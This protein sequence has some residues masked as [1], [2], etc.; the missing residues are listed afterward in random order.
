MRRFRHGPGSDGE[1]TE[2]L[3]E[4][5]KHLRGLAGRHL[6]PG[7]TLAI[8]VRD[9]DLAGRIEPRAACRAKSAS[10]AA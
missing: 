5:E 2:V 10:C 1:R 3:R 4:I 8:E 6:P 9:V 7:L